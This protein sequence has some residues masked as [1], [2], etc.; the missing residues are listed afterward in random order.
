[1]K[2][3]YI[4]GGLLGVLLCGLVAYAVMTFMSVQNTETAQQSPQAMP[5]LVLSEGTPAAAPQP[6]NDRLSDQVKA[7]GNVQSRVL[8]DSRKADEIKAD[9]L[10]GVRITLKNGRSITADFCREVSGKYICMVSGGRM[11]IDRKEIAS[12]R[13]VKLQGISSIDPSG[14]SSDAKADEGKAADKISAGANSAEP[15]A[16]KMTR[17]LTPE[18]MKRL[19]EITAKK[20]IMKP[21][22]E[23]LIKEREQLHEDVKNTGMI[24]SQSQFDGI[25]KRIADLETTI[26]NFNDDIKK[27]N[28]EEKGII[29]SAAAK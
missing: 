29:D 16:G 14:D 7:K 1:M 21:E 3:E 13:E 28:E 23:R 25:K 12:I 8:S 19:D 4:I 27:L 5:P 18:Q 9:T 26:V 2:K 20:E 17:G 11:E 6:A 22:R 15:G 24:W 10:T